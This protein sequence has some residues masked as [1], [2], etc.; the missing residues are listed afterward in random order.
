MCAL[1]RSGIAEQVKVEMSN[2]FPLVSVAIPLYKSLRFLD[3]I[4][5]NIKA[6]DYPNVEI[7]IS[8]R[9]CADNAIEI[10]E[11]RFKEDARCKFYKATDQINWPEHY[12]LLLQLATGQ[13]FC[14]M[15]HDDSY[16]ADYISK[17][18]TCL[19]ENPETLLAYGKM[20]TI[21]LN[22]Q[23]IENNFLHELPVGVNDP[24]TMLVAINLL[25]FQH[26]E[27]AFRGVFRREAVIG[28]QH[29]IRPTGR[30]VGCDTYW[31]FGLALL[32]R[33]QYVP[34]CN[35]RKR[36]YGDSTHVIQWSPQPELQRIIDGMKV[37]NSY[38][39]DY[40]PNCREAWLGYSLIFLYS[41]VRFASMCAR[42]L[43]ISRKWRRAVHRSIKSLF[44][45]RDRTN[46][47][48]KA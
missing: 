2:Q 26:L 13:Y 5:A 37:S 1:F 15:P 17:L 22:S 7:I 24:W 44:F 30:T 41:L 21:D 29:F 38:I 48:V 9:H 47:T 31:L 20:Q 3:I 11:E 12:N 28:A 40:V 32:G 25:A 18:V 16:P 36:F 10:L 4:I 42:S 34:S 39:R 14:W 46:L 27:T 8:D 43:G 6:I 19:E 23:Q 33:L 35:C 45:R